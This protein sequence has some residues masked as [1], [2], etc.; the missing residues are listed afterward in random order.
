MQ[1]G[2]AK[3]VPAGRPAISYPGRVRTES[4][5]VRAESRSIRQESRTLRSASARTRAQ[6][7]QARGVRAPYARVV[8]TQAGRPVRLLVSQDGSVGT[9]RQRR[10]RDPLRATLAVARE[11]DSVTSI[12]FARAGW[13][14]I[15]PFA[16]AAA[17]CDE[18]PSDTW[19]FFS[20]DESSDGATHRLRL[21]GE[22]DLASAAGLEE[23]LVAMAGSTV[24]ADLSQVRF[25]DARGIAALVSARRRIA[26]AGSQ[27]R[28]VGATA[29]VR[30]VLALVELESILDDLAR[31]AP[32]PR[33]PRPQ[34]ITGSA[35]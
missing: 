34:P 24:E 28:V 25:I 21:H 20:M 9:G 10:F 8:G 11:C 3:P 18:E 1:G 29:P 4:Q 7:T 30:R 19:P 2:R 16:E 17:L 27:L 12:V 33:R 23:R 13:R 14:P 5:H 26:E 32:R 15:V 6:A 35:L 31:S 22:L